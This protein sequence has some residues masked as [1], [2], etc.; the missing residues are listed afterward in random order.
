MNQRCNLLRASCRAVDGHTQL[1][2][3]QQRSSRYRDTSGGAT[4]LHSTCTPRA[5]PPGASTQQRRRTA[6]LPP[7]S[8][9]QQ[10]VD[11]AR[12]GVSADSLLTTPLVPV[13]PILA[14]LKYRRSYSL[15]LRLGPSRRPGCILSMTSSSRV[16]RLPRTRASRAA[17]A[18]I[19]TH[20][21]AYGHI[22]EPYT[23]VR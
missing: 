10:R 11:Q 20:P 15:M 23:P 3:E 13:L 2:H 17:R 6:V 18:G 4:T 8:S 14:R 12:F 16:P 22:I 7:M 9:S 5:P 19:A 1:H 21:A